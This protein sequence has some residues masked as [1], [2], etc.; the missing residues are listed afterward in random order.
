VAA[1]RIALAVLGVQPVF[2][3]PRLTRRSDAVLAG[4]DVPRS[5][6]HHAYLILELVKDAA[7][8]RAGVLMLAS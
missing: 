7:L 4:A 3:H 6:G 5:H 8:I 2:V 1:A